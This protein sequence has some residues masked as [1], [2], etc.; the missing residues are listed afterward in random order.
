M[1]MNRN[2]QTYKSYISFNGLRHLE[3]SLFHFYV[4]YDYMQ[5][6]TFE[7]FINCCKA[8]II[9]KKMHTPYNYPSILTSSS[10]SIS[11]SRV[12]GTLPVSHCTQKGDKYYRTQIYAFIISMREEEYVKTLGYKSM[13]NNVLPRRKKNTPRVWLQII[14]TI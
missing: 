8:C 4:P 12:C 13:M 14:M 5:E 6:Y 11:F 9:M 3:M 1:N 2:N 10:S 7:P